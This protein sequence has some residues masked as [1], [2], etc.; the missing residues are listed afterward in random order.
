MSPAFFVRV[1]RG[2]F[3]ETEFLI[4]CT[5]MVVAAISPA[6]GALTYLFL[7]PTPFSTAGLET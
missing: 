5:T 1:Q 6:P 3:C 4:C 7:V 2:L